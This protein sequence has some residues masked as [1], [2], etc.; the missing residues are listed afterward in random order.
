MAARTVL[1]S[2]AG[3]A[4]PTLAYWLGRFGLKPTIVEHAPSFRSGGYV[5]DF[6]GLGYGIA[7]RM[8]LA[9]G[10]ARLGYHMQ[11]L[12]VV[13]RDGRRVAGFGTGVFR[14]L[15]GG[16]FVSIRRSDLARLLLERAQPTSEIIFGDEIKAVRQ[17]AGG[18]EVTFAHAPPR[19]FDLVIGAD[20]L[21]SRVRQLAFG[22]QS[23][24]EKS[25]GYTVAAFEVSGYRPRD[26]GVYVMHNVPGRMIGRVALRNDRTLFLFVFA[27]DGSAP[28]HD[29]AA[30]KSLLQQRYKDSGWEIP[31]I[32]DALHAVDDLYFD[33]VSQIHMPRWS[34]GRIALVGDAAFCVSLMAGQGSALAM[35]A[36]Y[37]LAG[38]LGR[39]DSHAEAFQRYERLLRTYIETKQRAAVTFGGAFAPKTALGLAFRNLVIKATAIPGFARLTF[40]RDISDK[41]TLP[42]YSWK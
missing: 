35:T 4:G 1:V 11:E 28:A 29:V 16:R 42:E 38:E 24:F 13:G 21:H 32:L 25:L 20:G 41:L 37:V 8:G 27:D 36:A 30:Q 9:D 31:S 10:L 3:I 34:E 17:D 23:Q 15:T 39:C 19:T 22:P 33:R 6:W 18:V 5:I 7:E 14:E 26:E 40:G 2:G 12:R